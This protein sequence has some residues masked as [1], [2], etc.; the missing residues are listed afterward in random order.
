MEWWVEGGVWRDVITP[1]IYSLFFD[2]GTTLEL[3]LS[4]LLFSYLIKNNPP[5]IPPT[6]VV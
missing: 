4:I 3:F 5:P 1:Y 6:T 2:F